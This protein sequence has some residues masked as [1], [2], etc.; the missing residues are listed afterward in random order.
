MNLAIKIFYYS[1]LS[2]FLYSC[3]SQAP[4]GG[5]PRDN[6]PPK[7]IK[8]VP[9]NAEINV[10]SQQ[11]DFEFD[12][13]IQVKSINQKL[14]V[15]PPLKYTPELKLRAKGFSLIIKDTLKKNTTYNFYFA[16]AIQDLNE[17]N[18]L[19]DFNLVFSTGEIIDSIKLGGSI[20][21]ALTLKPEKNF[22]VLLYSDTTDSVPFKEK[23]NYL[24]K[25]NA[26]GIFQF[27]HLQ[28]GYYKLVAISDK[29]NNYLFDAGSEKIAFASQPINLD[30]YID[31]LKLY[32]FDEDR[33]KQYIKKKDRKYRFK[34]ELY[35]NAPSPEPPKVL[36]STAKL[37]DTYVSHNNDSIFIFFA[38][39]SQYANDTIRFNIT[40]AYFDSLL[41][42]VYKTE[43]VELPYNADKKISSGSL[44]FQWSVKNFKIPASEPL[45]IEFSEPVLNVENAIIIEQMLADS[46]FKKISTLVQKDNKNTLRWNIQTSLLSGQKYRFVLNANNITSPYQHKLL[47]D[48][49][50]IQTLQPE[51]FANLKLNMTIPF[52]NKYLVIELLNDKNQRLR[53]YT[54]TE[55]QTINIQHLEPGKYNLRCFIDENQNGKWDNG[56]YILKKQPEKVYIYP[57]TFQL[58]ANWDLELNWKIEK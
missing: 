9:Q 39:S 49:L 5:G 8:S 23:P 50:I 55:N 46:T 47:S 57:Q 1:I 30:K 32:S 35:F 45:H 7:L 14:L 44:T 33:T 25:T 56:Y 13:F 12:E 52:K 10:Q 18:V 42:K 28:K 48:T 6:N 53:T 29:N 54:I 38:D 4:L 43:Y 26:D 58:R 41:N 11:L 22:L 36:Q 3:A 34:A 31:T 37:L 2:F 24:T 40:Y 20:V 21:D 27:N 17:N 15:S 19:N 16:D 51:D